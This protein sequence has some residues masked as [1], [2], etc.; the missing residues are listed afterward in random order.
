MAVQVIV[1]PP[2]P[3]AW[4]VPSLEL[5][6]QSAHTA[7]KVWHLGCAW[8]AD[9]WLHAC[10]GRS[11]EVSKARLNTIRG[12][13]AADRIDEELYH[14]FE[15]DA[16]KKVGAGCGVCTSLWWWRAALGMLA[17]F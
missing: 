15:T 16:A 9:L 7:G 1:K 10:A 6:T 17:G 4:N 8:D 5:C 13:E 14:D 11:E 3:L 12:V 2:P